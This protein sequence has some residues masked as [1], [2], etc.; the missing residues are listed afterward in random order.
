[1]K[2]VFTQMNDVISADINEILNQSEKEMD[3][4]ARQIKWAIGHD[5]I[6]IV[7]VSRIGA[8]YPVC[9]YAA[10]LENGKTFVIS[11][12]TGPHWAL[13]GNTLEW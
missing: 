11:F 9:T 7:Q 5:A 12:Q 2:N 1:M 8:E 4:V 13:Q 6:H 3:C 10:K